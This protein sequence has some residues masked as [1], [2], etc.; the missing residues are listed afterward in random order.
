MAG[1]WIEI[2]RRRLLANVA[3]F[4][5]RLGS[6]CQLMAVVK[7][8]AYGHDAFLVSEA[9]Q[10]KVD[11]FGV[12]SVREAFELSMVGV[13][14]RPRRPL[15][16]LGH[17][18]ADSAETIVARGFRQALFR[19]DVAEALSRAAT[20]LSR[21]AYV[22]LKIETGLYRLG[23]TPQEL[24]GFARFLKELDGLIVEGVYTHFAHVED[25]TSDFYQEQLRQLWDTLEVL[26]KQGLEPSLVHA[27]PSAGALLHARDKMALAR[28][29]I[30]IY[31]I[32]PS[33]DTRDALDDLELQPVLAWKCRIAQVK[34]VPAGA[35]VGYDRTYRAPTD[36]RIAVI[37]VGYSDGLDR[38]LSGRGSVLVRGRRAPIVGRVAM[39]MTMIDVSEAAAEADDEVVLIGEQGDEILTAEEIASWSDT[40][41]HEVVARLPRELPRTIG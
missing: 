7:G 16:V 33:V 35:S 40:I 32:W 11:W 6:A 41:A 1:S 31:G 25:P 18:E 26:R 37:P 2:D 5:K 12:S 3:V 27:S 36:R 9:I 38:S 17:T 34:S 29:G 24:A 19:R 10:G 22:H 21:P 14:R 13:D 20:K 8:N 39:N 15:I 4:R 23:V 30:G 28:I